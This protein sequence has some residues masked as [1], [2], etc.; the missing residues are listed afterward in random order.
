MALA[1]LFED[2]FKKPTCSYIAG[3]GTEVGE[4]SLSLYLEIYLK[5]MIF[6]S[7]ELYHL[8]FGS[9]VS[10]VRTSEDDYTI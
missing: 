9:P 6:F 8:W 7:S 5:V 4:A 3:L 10:A 1:S 2:S